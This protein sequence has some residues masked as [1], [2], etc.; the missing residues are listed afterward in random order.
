[1]TAQNDIRR[2]KTFQTLFEF[3]HAARSKLLDRRD[4]SDDAGERKKLADKA[5]EYSKFLTRIRRAQIV[6]LT[7]PPEDG[8]PSAV[9]QL[10][11]AVAVARS[12][13][14]EL[15]QLA[16]ALKAATELLAMAQ[17]LVKIIS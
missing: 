4:E 6:E 15:E 9:A 16:T 1:M 13:L 11:N 7:T 12:R 8:G 10:N 2:L 3:G 14:E 17:R 5:Q